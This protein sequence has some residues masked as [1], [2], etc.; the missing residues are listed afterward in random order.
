MSCCAIPLTLRAVENVLQDGETKSALIS[1]ERKFSK[2]DVRSLYFTT[3]A[4]IV[5]VLVLLFVIAG[6]EETDKTKQMITVEC[7]FMICFALGNTLLRIWNLK[8]SMLQ[9]VLTIW[10][11][12]SG[13]IADK[14]MFFWSVFFG[15]AGVL[16]MIGVVI[17]LF[18]N[19]YVLSIILTCVDC[20]IFILCSVFYRLHVGVYISKVITSTSRV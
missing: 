18:K 20:F 11:E 2:N 17:S 3:L 15:F 6:M 16:L 8:F 19:S 1:Y 13:I 14:W 4:M 10:R 7:I 12:F 5:N 9:P